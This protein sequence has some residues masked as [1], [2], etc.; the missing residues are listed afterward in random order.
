MGEHTVSSFDDDLAHIDRLFR[1]MG[2]L[3]G[4]M[5]S[6]STRALLNSDDSLAQRVIS[7]DAVMDARQRELDE[8]AITLIAKRQPMAQDLRAVVGAIRMAADLE[9]ILSPRH[10]VAVRGTYGGPAP[11]ETARASAESSAQ[12]ESDRTW[13]ASETDRLTA[14]ERRLAERAAAL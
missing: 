2:R 7:E 14:A 12:L 1:D 4:S 3:S 5:L 9:R 10:F 8:R 13:W 11:E 6:G